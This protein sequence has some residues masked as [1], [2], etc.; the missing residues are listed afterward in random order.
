MA[1]TTPRTGYAP[2]NSL[3]LYYEIHGDGEPLVVLHGTYMTI[4]TMG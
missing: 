4:S 2:I 1:N 3:N